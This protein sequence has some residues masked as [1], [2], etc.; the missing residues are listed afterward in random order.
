MKRLFILLSF[1]LGLFYFVSLGL[2]AEGEA[3]HG[4]TPS[5]IRNLI[6]WT[7]NFIALIIILYKLLKKPVVNFFKNRKENILKEYEELLAKKKEAEAKYLELQE[8]I[9]NLKAEAEAIYQNYVEQGIKEKERILEE[10]QLQAKRIKEQ[11]QLYIAQEMEKA[12]ERL[13][14]ELAEEAVKLAEEILRKN[15]TPEDQKRV[16]KEVLEQ[17]K[18]RSLN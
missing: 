2:A 6:W 7:V 16:F 15:I 1:F 8:K 17:I 11:A 13:K 18:G 14:F 4:V 3:S 9:K 12:K 10:A 5:Q